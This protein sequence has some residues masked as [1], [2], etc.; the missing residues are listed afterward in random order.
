MMK[1]HIDKAIEAIAAKVSS[2]EISAACIEE[3]QRRFNLSD[4]ELKYVE[5]LMISERQTALDQGR[6]HLT[7]SIDAFVEHGRQWG[8]KQA[9]VEF[10]AH[11]H[12]WTRL[13]LIQ[14]ADRVVEHWDAT[15]ADVGE[16]GDDF[17]M[18]LVCE[19]AAA[20]RE[21]LVTRLVELSANFVPENG[22]AS[23]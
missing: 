17:E 16:S 10:L 4:D 3:I 21:A 18:D 9:E 6:S 7:E 5:D 22:G 12:R 20:S 8:R 1:Q 14:V 19:M 15:Y 2:D 13:E 23:A 11:P